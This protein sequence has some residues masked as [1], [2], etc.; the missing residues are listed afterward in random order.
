M[1]PKALQPLLAPRSIAIIGASESPDSWAP[2][3]YS[4]LVHLDFE[5]ELYP[6]HPKY[7]RVWG[8]DCYPSIL[9]VPKPVDLAVYVIRGDRVVADI[10]NAAKAG[11]RSLMVI[12]S[13]F[14]ETGEEGRALQ[15]E[16]RAKALK[17]KL[18]LLGPNIEGFV[19][20]T[21]KVAPYGTLPP[22]HPV[23]GDI[24]VISQSGTVAWAMNQQ[25]SDRG[26]GLRVILGVGNEAVIGLGDMFEWAA[27]DRHTKVVCSYIETMRDV[28]GI[29]KGLKALAAAGKPV[30][31]CAPSGRSEAAQRAIVAHTGALAGNTGV[32]DAWLLG[33]G[34]VLVEDP[35]VMFE[36]AV[37]ISHHKTTRT[38]G[39]TAALQSGGACTLFAEAAGAEGLDLPAFAKATERR[40]KA[41]LPSFANLNN[42]LDVTGQAA[43]ETDMYCDALDALAHD[44]SI[45]FIGID[46]FPPRGDDEHDAVWALPVLNKAKRLEKETG[47]S[48]ASIS[49]TPLKYMEGA[50][51]FVKRV[52]MPFLQGHRAAAGAVKALMDNQGTKAA[53]T[54][55]LAAHAN[56][57]KAIKLLKGLDGPL[58]EEQAAR[59]LEWYGVKRPKEKLVDTPAQSV[60]F[61]RTIK[62]PFAVKAAAPEIPHKAKLG[63]VRL[64]LTTLIDVEAA[65]TEVLAAARKAGARAPK[66]LVQEMASGAEVLIG[67][68]VDHQFGPA[69]TIRP[70]GALAEA[71][72]ATF[73]AAPLSAKQALA[74]V[75]S[76]AE[77]CN[78]DPAKHDLEAVAKVVRSIAHAASDLRDR[79]T[80]LEA[81]PLL[82]GKRGAVAVDALAEARA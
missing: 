33:L 17:H 2:E 65:A 22:P 16:L 39:V 29:E 68:I 61:A 44:P 38:T 18:P 72:E 74:F 32:R 40:L 11:V 13:G 14:A 27:Q 53:T 4:S 5:G 59:I 37:L 64:N 57:T 49:M 23:A 9:D 80:S 26:V 51:S 47:V 21:D 10:D 50:R 75:E 45:G 69:I 30:L 58:D 41:A 20:Y 78:L 52:G 3:I 8:L 35:V 81:N 34:V 55:P 48:F 67:A 73:V 46:A 63:G 28:A 31:L 1:N 71:G 62:G 79:I 76:Q 82:V 24:S 60:A 66:V 12:A 25:A 6:V 70:G 7:D 36:A 42:P 77:R 54:K 19:N 43:V 56:R 15:E